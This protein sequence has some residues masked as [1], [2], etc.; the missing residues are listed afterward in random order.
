[1]RRTFTILALVVCALIEFY[2]YPGHSYL[3]G[4]SQVIV[5]MLERLQFPGLLSRDLVAT[6]PIL[7]YTAFDEMTLALTRIV[8][9]NLENALALQLF[10]ARLAALA[11]AFLLAASCGLG[12]FASLLVASVTG[13]GVALPALHLFTSGHEAEP[14]TLALGWSVFATGLFV[15]GRAA[16]SGLAGGA[17]LLYS[18]AVALTWWFCV[19][20]AAAWR[21]PS[22]LLLRTLL[23]TFAVAALLLANLIQLQPGAANGTA[24]FSPISPGWERLLEQRTPEVLVRTWIGREAW[25]FSAMI[26]AGS[27][28]L[29]RWRGRFRPTAKRFVYVLLLAAFVSMP[30]AWTGQQYLRWPLFLSLDPGR[31]LALAVIVCLTLW[32]LAAVLAWRE[33]KR[34]ESSLWGA[35]AC[36]L[37]FLSVFARPMAPSPVFSDASIKAVSEWAQSSTWGGSMFLFANDGTRADPG[38]FRA[39]ALRPVYVDWQSGILSRWSE[40][41][42][43]EWSARWNRVRVQTSSARQIAGLLNEPIDYYVTPQRDRLAGVQPV[44]ANG[45]LLVYDA[46]DLRDRRELL[47][48]RTATPSN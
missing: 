16:A 14:F 11:G 30:A 33:R 5:P 4:E 15:A 2:V 48:A 22:R 38:R 9:L 35:A 7:R 18:P 46:R 39:L 44:F 32:M 42:A 41:F 12:R 36:T 8:R 20:L 26:V 40:E 45:E 21:R 28:A 24:L 37:V 31:I 1:M 47:P 23:T 43:S 10:A 17:A 25:L 6:H 29:F 34:M 27:C 19:M 3:R 13:L